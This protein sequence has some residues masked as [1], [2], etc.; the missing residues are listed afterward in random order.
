MKHFFTLFLLLG[1]I[2]ACSQSYFTGVYGD[3]ESNLIVKYAHSESGG[4]LYGVGFEGTVVKYD[5]DGLLIYM[6]KVD[7]AFYFY[8]FVE[9]NDKSLLVAGMLIVDGLKQS[10]VTK[11]SEEGYIEWVKLYGSGV[12]QMQQQ[13]VKPVDDVDEFILA[14]WYLASGSG[15]D[16]ALTKLDADGEIVWNYKY[17]YVDD[18]NDGIVPDGEGGVYVVGQSAGGDGDGNI[19]QVSGSGDFIRSK[20]F[21][22]LPYAFH[23]VIKAIDGSI[24]I[25]GDSYNSDLDDGRNPILVK[26][27]SDLEFQWMREIQ[28]GSSLGTYPITGG[29]DV[30][31]DHN[32]NV[33][34]TSVI[35]HDDETQQSIAKFSS[36]GN[37]IWNK[38][39]GY[40]LNTE[41]FFVCINEFYN[42]SQE[43]I[44]FSNS[45]DDG[46]SIFGESDV[47]LMN[48]GPDGES[49]Y[50]EDIS[51]IIDDPELIATDANYDREDLS[52]SIDELVY[53]A[54]SGQWNETSCDAFEGVHEEMFQNNQIIVYPNPAAKYVIIDCDKIIL[55]GTNLEITIN[56]L[57]G[58]IVDSKSALTT[59]NPILIQTF[60]IPAGLYTIRITSAKEIY[61][62]QIVIG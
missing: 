31:E 40:S 1:S 43:F 9:T 15:D 57:N 23:K 5:S 8:D 41:P 7:P 35:F 6:K 33:Y 14:S 39:M 47:Q 28:S 24:Y 45:R 30:A 38:T 29:G 62:K 17:D 42:G 13:I 2:Q 54:D 44:T 4:Y 61:T 53:S 3:E 55:A 32:G 59:G 49:C 12:R 56:N 50:L 52:Y 34:I 51:I 26:L 16:I 37:T 25:A 10:I 46:I 20:S 60:G 27:N 36:T 21:G 11:L 58:Q 19:M 22:D 48:I 18:Q